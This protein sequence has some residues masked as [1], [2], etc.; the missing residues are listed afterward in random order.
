MD[1]QIPP[2]EQAR[3][4]VRRHGR[5]SQITRWPTA[6]RGPV[7]R[8]TRGARRH[9][10]ARR[11]HRDH[12]PQVRHSRR[13]RRGGRRGSAPAWRRGSREGSR[14]G[15]P[16]SVPRSTVTIDGEHARDFDDAITIERLPNGNYWLGV[17]IADVAHYVPEGGALDEE[18]YER[19]TSVYFPGPRGAHVP[20]GALDRSLQPESRR[21]SAGA[22]LP[23]GSRPQGARSCATRSTT[24]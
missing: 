2:G 1:V 19:A 9:R 22:V 8:V 6:A 7:G 12:H 10:R 4:Q 15:G 5:R 11:R 14:A 23:D 13:A 16:T 3:R 21:R 17:H 20:V 18:A 24:A